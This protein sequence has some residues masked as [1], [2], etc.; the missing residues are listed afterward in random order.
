MYLNYYFNIFLLM[1][2]LNVN[3]AFV[4]KYINCQIFS[5][6]IFNPS[7]NCTKTFYV[8]KENLIYCA[9]EYDLLHSL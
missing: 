7:F 2:T 8:V 4:Q 6:I 1:F 5:K 3:N 9:L